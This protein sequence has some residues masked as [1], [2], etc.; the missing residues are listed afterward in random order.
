MEKCNK[1]SQKILFWSTVLYRISVTAETVIFMWLFGVI[2]EDM[3][4]IPATSAQG[5]LY[6]G[7]LWNVVN[8]LTYWVWHYFLYRWFGHKIVT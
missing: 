1:V 2:L 4:N 7:I 5:A 6:I 3:F 8:M